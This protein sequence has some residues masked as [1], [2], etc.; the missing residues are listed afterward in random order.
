VLSEL[1]ISVLPAGGGTE[2][3]DVVAGSNNIPNATAVSRSSV[4]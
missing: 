4:L 1:M 2:A 3:T